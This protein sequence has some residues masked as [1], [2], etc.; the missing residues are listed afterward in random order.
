MA[1]TAWSNPARS[2]AMVGL[3]ALAAV[4][5]VHLFA[6]P[7][8]PTSAL[9][10]HALVIA[11]AYT[12]GFALAYLPVVKLW[13]RRRPR[14]A[15]PHWLLAATVATG[16]LIGLALLFLAV[17]LGLGGPD[18]GHR[19]SFWL[20][21][22]T[23]V[24]A[25]LTALFLF[26]ERGRQLRAELERIGRRGPVVDTAPGSP[27]IELEAGRRRLLARVDEIHFAAAQENYCEVVLADGQRL[28]IR[29]T[30]TELLGRMPQPPFAR[31]HRSFLVNLR[32]VREI[33]PVGRAYQARLRGSNAQIPVSRGEI[34]AVM[35]IWR[36]MT[37][38]LG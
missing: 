32:A 12:A 23:P 14:R 20:L 18:G 16:F 22:L 13:H 9:L 6:T 3:L 26:A 35:E 24:G 25:A 8:L 28:L 15:A 17:R 5:L 31:T 7:E 4:L 30:L 36:G 10:G 21:R 34:E 1:Q 19:D 29:S 11:F 27:P 38:G 37:P 33:E 2:V